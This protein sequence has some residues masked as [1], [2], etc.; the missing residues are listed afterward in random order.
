[1]CWVLAH[2]LPKTPQKEKSFILK[3]SLRSNE[4]KE[5][6]KDPLVRFMYAFPA[7]KLD[8]FPSKTFH[9]YLKWFFSLADWNEWGCF[10]ASESAKLL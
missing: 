1:M 6:A 3:Q 9:F 2:T 8:F 7:E 4:K 5:A 10:L